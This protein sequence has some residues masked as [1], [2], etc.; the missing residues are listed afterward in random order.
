[1]KA[2]GFSFVA[3]VVLVIGAS[4]RTGLPVFAQQTTQQQ[5]ITTVEPPASVRVGDTLAIVVHLTTGEGVPIENQPVIV[6]A[7]TLFGG[8]E[9][10]QGRGTT[11]ATGLAVVRLRSLPVGQMTFVAT[12]AGSITRGLAP[13]ESAPDTL[14]VLALIAPILRFDP[15]PVVPLGSR[16]RLVLHAEESTGEAIAGINVLITLDG[17][18][19]GTILTDERGQGDIALKSGLTSGTHAVGASYSG[20]PSKKIAPATAVSSVDVGTAWLQIQTVPPV[21]GVRFQLTELPASGDPGQV[22][23]FTSDAN[24]LAFVAFDSSGGYAL[25]AAADPDQAAS[26]RRAQFAR[27]FDDYFQPSRLLYLGSSRRLSVG[28]DLDYEV[29]HA[30]RDL[31]QQPVDASRVTSVTLTN[32]LGEE[33]TLTSDQP[34]WLRGSRV[35]RRASGLEESKILYSVKRVIMNGSNVV[36]QDE[37]R[38]YPEQGQLLPITLSLFSMHISTRDA[39][40]GFSVGRAI[41]LV[42]PDGHTERVPFGP[43]GDL[44]LPALPRGTYKLKI[45]GWGFS[46]LP[47]VALSRNQEVE[48][49]VISYLDI[50]LVGT[51]GFVVVFGLLAVGRWRLLNWRRTRA[52][53]F[54]LG[55]LERGELR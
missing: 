32:S 49:R 16:Q 20:S 6:A 17:E 54:L 14:E 41:H 35:I 2:V 42:Y 15:V 4:T 38:F 36:N 5:T 11:D 26:G 3:V 23:A 30:F 1:M 55:G 29:G 7:E 34:A 22:R 50:A 45:D 12:Y 19:L 53:P 39:L 21:P 33:T 13:S 51:L 43:N 52:A 10:I 46:S 25:S 44:S 40:F 24:G 8:G 18:Q 28:F 47:S 31:A 37:Q 48:V 27:W 9:P